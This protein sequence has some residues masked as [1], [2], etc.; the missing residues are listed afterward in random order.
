MRLRFTLLATVAGL[1]AAGCNSPDA[2]LNA[3]PHGK[4][5]E[6]SDLQGTLVYM[7]DNAMLA[8]MHMSDHHF[9]PHRAML[10]SLGEERLSRM[11]QLMQ[12]YGGDLR[13]SSNLA[14]DAPLRKQRV[15]TLVQFLNEVGIP[16]TADAVRDDMP[17]GRGMDAGSAVLIKMNEGT[18]KPR[19]KSSQTGASAGAGAASN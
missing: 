9:L 15:D 2:R 3:P 14:A 13:Y 18:Y 8:D 5:E 4:A 12:S 1:A 6:T 11:A 19:S 10:T 17:G 16:V 7:S